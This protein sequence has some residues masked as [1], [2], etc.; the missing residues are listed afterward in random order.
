MKELQEAKIVF[1][2]EA[3]P[4]LSHFFSQNLKSG[5]HCLLFSPR[6]PGSFATGFERMFLGSCLRSTNAISLFANRFIE[7]GAQEF[8]KTWRGNNLEGELVNVKFVKK[9]MREKLV[10]D[11]F[12]LIF[13]EE[14]CK[15]SA[16]KA[17]LGFLVI[18]SFIELELLNEVQRILETRQYTTFKSIPPLWRTPHRNVDHLPDIYFCDPEEVEGCEFAFILILLDLENL[19]IITSPFF[20]NHFLTAVTRATLK[21][22]I[23]VKDYDLADEEQIENCLARFGGENIKTAI[24]ERLKNSNNNSI[25][26]FVGQMPNALDKASDSGITGISVYQQNTFLHTDDIFLESDLEKLSELNVHQIFLANTNLS[27]KLDYFF[28]FASARCIKNFCER[29]SSNLSLFDK[30][31]NSTTMTYRLKTFE[32]FLRQN[33][34]FSNE[35][36]RTFWHEIEDST[37]LLLNQQMSWDKWVTKAEE[38]YRI[39]DVIFSI[40]A[41]EVSMNLLQKQWKQNEVTE[42]LEMANM[43]RKNLAKLCA[44][45]SRMFIEQIDTIVQQTRSDF[46]FQ[47]LFVEDCLM[48]AFIHAANALQLDICF[49]Y[50]H[51]VETVTEKMR[52]Y[53]TED[54]IGVALTHFDIEKSFGIELRGMQRKALF[55]EASLSAEFDSKLEALD[56]LI[57]CHNRNISSSGN[58][59]LLRRR[60]ISY[61]AIK[62]SE[63]SFCQILNACGEDGNAEKQFKTLFHAMMKIF[64]YPVQLALLAKHWQ[65][66]DKCSQ[67]LKPAFD[68]LETSFH[69]LM[70][71]VD[72]DEN[73]VQLNKTKSSTDLIKVRFHSFRNS[74]QRKNLAVLNSSVSQIDF[75]LLQKQRSRSYMKNCRF[76]IFTSGFSATYAVVYPM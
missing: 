67:V 38:L 53:S 26:L 21:V 60:K 50:C 41:L 45:V 23:I 72:H 71:Y 68:E 61:M 52:L 76:Y 5:Q 58:R 15:S 69:N 74:L 35:F 29:P 2:D 16:M 11:E 30:S 62:L 51:L 66:S 63:E 10:S 43:D 14:I 42:N 64:E 73:R 56:S 18:V 9:N 65:I 54:N 44:T 13:V 27:C 1:C 4:Q 6:V 17:H 19:E 33:A 22:D 25:V 55:P 37:S 48:K 70:N 46:D 47:V 20:R 49:Q 34:E 12:A 28:Y 24:K 3:S 7:T 31:F 36:H 40:M 59:E 57:C 39:N 8:L 75:I 32:A